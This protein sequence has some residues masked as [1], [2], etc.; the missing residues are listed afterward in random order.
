MRRLVKHIV[1]ELPIISLAQE[2]WE[3][4]FLDSH[5]TDLIKEIKIDG[6]ILIEF[7]IDVYRDMDFQITDVIP[8]YIKIM[9][10]DYEELDVTE[11]EKDLIF[12]ELAN[13]I[14]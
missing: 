9:D 8:H 4:E 1:H 7:K 14:R 6:D 13:C 10:F 2:D 12:D 3:W 5:I 11:Q